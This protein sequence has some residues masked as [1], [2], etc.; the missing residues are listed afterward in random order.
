MTK[1]VDFYYDYISP[2]SYLAWT[3][4]VDICKRSNATINYKPM[5]LGGVLKANASNSP[6]N[7]PAK[8]EWMKADFIRYANYYGVPYQL[9][10]H[11]IFSTVNAMRGA[12]WALSN[13]Q[14]EA[15]N[16]AM[17]TA[18]WV[19]GK[20]LSDNNVLADILEGA[21]INSSAALESM[22][23]SKMKSA[24][25]QSTEDAVKLGIFGAPSMII[26]GEI[27]FGQDRLIW[28]ERALSK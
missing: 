20:D 24:L 17:F 11:F 21:G 16:Q 13:N 19:E 7:I 1:T 10:P 3:Q 9:N 27:F 15:Y 2:A 4:L 14:I 23:N 28:V 8:W 5:F 18:A 25:I 22:T 6:V 12:I 26:D